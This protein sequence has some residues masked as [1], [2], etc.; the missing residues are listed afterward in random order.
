MKSLVWFSFTLLL[1]IAP[2][3]ASAVE[4]SI[5]Q[6]EARVFDFT[7]P[8]DQSEYLSRYPQHRQSSRIADFVIALS[9][10]GVLED[11][12]A[13]ATVVGFLA[14]IFR[15]ERQSIGLWYDAWLRGLPPRHLKVIHSAMLYSRT[16][17]A[18]A[19]MLRLFGDHYRQQKTEVKKILEM[20]IDSVLTLPMLWGFYYATE[21]ETALRRVVLCFRLEAAPE[22]LEGFETPEGFTPY[23]QLLPDLAFEGLIDAAREHPPVL[24]TLKAFLE[25]AEAGEKP[26]DEF[27]TDQEKAGIERVMAALA[28]EN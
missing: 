26:A 28:S 17:E 8:E 5:D 25:Q 14:Q 23:Y 6:S 21:S 9:R 7:K 22:K 13:R 11:D 2:A 10:D 16:G 18:D 19:L 12:R 24:D 27:L 1:I 20:P 3:S 15:Q 4:K